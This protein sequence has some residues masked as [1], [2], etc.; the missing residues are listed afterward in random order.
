MIAAAGI[1]DGLYRSA[2]HFARTPKGLLT[3]VLLPILAVAVWSEGAAL[4]LPGVLAAVTAAVLT[5]IGVVR[6]GKGVWA[7]PSGAMLS[8][9]FVAMVLSPH[10][11]LV[12]PVAASVLAV[13]SKHLFR[14]GP[15]NVFNPAA[16]ALV[17]TAILFG[18]GQDWWGA[19][20]SLGWAGL[21]LLL[22][23]GWFIADHVNKVP[24]VLA[25]LGTYFGLFTI[26]AFLP[27][28]REVSEVF[29]APDVHATLF[30]AF[31]MLDDPP[32]C[33]VH[34]RDQAWFAALVAGGSFIAF[35]A[36]GWLYYLL[37]GLLVGNAAWGGVRTTRG[38]LRSRRRAA[39]ARSQRERTAAV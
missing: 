26:A 1:H 6:L 21:P 16:L 27:G 2:L 35:E 34:Y 30:F 13:S 36:W 9:L 14:L 5:D 39:V 4:A 25:F 17:M 38:W 19:L 28:G 10:E 7:G 15:A 37:A 11:H 23:T 8:G 29:R 12:I 3:A 33:P 22:V 24:L 20:P 18:A 31:F 32:T